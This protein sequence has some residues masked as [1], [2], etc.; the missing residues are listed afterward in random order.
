MELYEAYLR[1]AG[2]E[3]VYTAF[4]GREAVR[5]NRETP[6]PVIIMN[7]MMIHMHGIEATRKILGEF[8][9][10]K[11]ILESTRDVGKEAV[12]AGA[13]VFLLGP[14][15]PESLLGAVSRA[16]KKTP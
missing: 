1:Q 16:T 5:K 3:I 8:P 11:V 9:G 14:V 4:D 15:S 10:T 13:A 2:H 12:A 7:Y 6:A